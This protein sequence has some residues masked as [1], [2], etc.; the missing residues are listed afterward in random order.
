MEHERQGFE[1]GVLFGVGSDLQ[2]TERLRRTGAHSM[3]YQFT[4]NAPSVYTRPWT[5][6]TPMRGSTGRSASTHA[7]KGNY[8]VTNM[9]KGA[10]AQ[11]K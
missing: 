11:E 5:M 10:R 4:V 6:A 8:T 3:D 9:L 2:L 1:R 7:M